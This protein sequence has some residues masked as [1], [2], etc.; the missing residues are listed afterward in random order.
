MFSNNVDNELLFNKATQCLQKGKNEEAVSLFD[1]LIMKEPEN[2]HFLN[3][4]GSGLM[5]AG[6]LDDAEEVFDK[7]LSIKDNPMALLNKAFI[8]GYKNDY[9][10]AILYCD[11]AI[12][13]DP[14]LK[15]MVLD[16]KNGFIEK[17]AENSG[18]DEF[19]S[20]AQELID[21]A[22]RLKEEESYWEGEH[23]FELEPVYPKFKKVTF[24]EAWELYEDAIRKDANCESVVVSYINKLKSSFI[25]E[26]MFFDIT[27]R[28][29]FHIE[30]NLSRLKLNIIKQMF[31]GKNF[32]RAQAL[33]DE[34]LETIDEND[35]DAINYKGVLLFYYDEVD[36]AIECFDKLIETGDE[37]YSFYAKF[38]KAFAL[39]RKSM[40]SGDLDYMVQALDIY[41]EMLKNSSIFNKIKPYQREILDKLQG[42]MKV[43]LF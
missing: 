6:R 38:N 24:W 37:I 23:V 15:L 1:Q 3:G 13:L 39:R 33:V 42:F 28:D 34:I 20:E 25:Q 40:I 32:I 7:S 29:D 35:L 21:K 27:Q 2:V 9:D 4:K 43:P 8:Y 41:D 22:N 11:K 12:D 18:P 16:I 31:L 10:N 26:F 19:N 36:E 5:Q 17:K 14:N 30:S